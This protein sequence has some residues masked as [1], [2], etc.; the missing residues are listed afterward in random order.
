MFENG[1]EMQEGRCSLEN[2]RDGVSHVTKSLKNGVSQ[3]I[4]FK[5]KI[6]F[7]QLE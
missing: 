7:D 5:K 6:K 4:L 1:Y 3:V 2:G